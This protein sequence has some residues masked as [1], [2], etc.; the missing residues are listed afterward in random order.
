M[1]PLVLA[2]LLAS[3]GHE[4][5]NSADTINKPF[6]VDGVRV[7]PE[8][9]NAYLVAHRGFTSRGGEMRCAYTS[10]GQRGSR[11]FV[12]ALC[13]ELVVIDGH[14]VDGS[15]MSLPTAFAIAVDNGRAR[16]TGAEVPADGN[17]YAPSIRRIFPATTWPAIFADR[18]RAVAGL[19]H[20]LREE[21]TA[22]FGLPPAAADAP[23]R[24]EP[25][26]SISAATLDSSARRVVE[27]LRGKALFE[28]IDLSDTVTLSVSPEGGG[29][30]ASF[31][32][33]ELRNPSAW[34]VRSGDHTFSFVPPAGLTKLTT[35]LGRH[36]NCKEEALASKFP[37]FAQLPHVGTILEPENATS[38][39]ETW[40]VT[41]VFDRGIRPRVIAALYDQ[42][43]W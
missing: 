27:F 17:D 34:R 42:W 30:R 19:E 38:C 40:N 9:L 16:V 18:R 32:R 24:H 20:H 25:P 6:A 14:L 36:F 11:L 22:R 1:R 15:A 35:R 7:E 29:G 43:E 39:L 8:S 33:D 23:R 37:R 5:S 28:Q 31:A 13:S 2:L 10:L 12:W 3:C 26:R 41:F 21:A 4:K